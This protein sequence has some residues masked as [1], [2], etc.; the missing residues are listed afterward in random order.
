M[1]KTLFRKECLK[2]LK[3][4]SNYVRSKKI[5]K[6]L[7]EILSNKKYRNILLYLSLNNEV[8]TK[9]LIKKLKRQNKNVF[10]PFMEDIS[11]KM[12]KYS[13][14][15]KKK[16]FNIYEPKNKNKTK[17]KIDI[18]VVPII[19][20]DGNFKRIGFGKGMYD[21]FFDKLKYKIKI[22]FIQIYPCITKSIITD[23]YDITAD[24]YLSYNLIC[25]RR[26][27]DNRS[28]DR[29]RSIPSSRFFHS[30]KIR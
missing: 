30:K 17:Y 2:I 18:A 3:K 26:K 13:L 14:P 12:V 11:F 6:K 24:L 8:T 22:I 28:V 20:I 10:V 16:K 25:D 7:L 1:N 4:K 15:L 29:L 21:R 5:E 23:K 27:N 19:G 9:N